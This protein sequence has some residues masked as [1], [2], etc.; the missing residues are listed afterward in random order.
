M[1]LKGNIEH[2][3]LDETKVPEVRPLERWRQCLLDG[4]DLIEKHGWRQFDLGDPTR[5]F[6]ILGAMLEAAKHGGH[7]DAA[8]VCDA[9]NRLAAQTGQRMWTVA[10][11]N[12]A[13]GR[14]KEQVISAMRAAA[15]A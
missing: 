14:T 9:A 2:L 13:P 7:T 5:G 1:Y 15:N 8:L 4:A 6:C 3:L 12:N 10:Q 11:W